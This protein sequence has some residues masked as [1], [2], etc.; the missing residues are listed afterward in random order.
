MENKEYIQEYM[1]KMNE[2]RA[3]LLTFL[4]CD[5]DQE[6]KFD[7]IVK[8]LDDHKIREDKIKLKIIL[9][10]IATIASNNYQSTNF[11]TKIYQLLRFFF[12][13]IQKYYTNIE[14]FYI[15]RRHK[16]ILLFLFDHE[17][18][19]PQK[20]IASFLTEEKYIQKEYSS[21]FYP[22]FENF[23]KGNDKI[24]IHPKLLENNYEILKKAR[25]VINFYKDIQKLIRKDSLNDF[26]SYVSSKNI[27]LD[28]KVTKT[29]L[30]WDLFVIKNEIRLIDYAA[31]SGSAQIFK[32]L[33]SNKIELK[34]FLWLCAIRGNNTEIIHILEDSNVQPPDNNFLICFK[35]AVKCHHNDFAKYFKNNH[36]NDDGENK[37][38][39]ISICIKYYNF[40]MLNEIDFSIDDLTNQDILYSLI[41]GGFLDIVDFIIKNASKTVDLNIISNAY[42]NSIKTSFCFE[43][44]FKII[45]F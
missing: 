25:K 43:Y 31:L 44:S 28:F 19:I 40:E 15:F 5:D 10:L 7:T 16:Q 21:Y 35:E 4:E 14:I 2:I 11:I 27:P 20:N 41:K 32:Y 23:F 29:I 24:K 22:E 17:I 33:V 45:Y 12:N 34:P 36:L 3:F 37:L 38:A 39:L 1:N 6:D 26:I 9:H 13:E 42:F 30:E 8:H 18:L